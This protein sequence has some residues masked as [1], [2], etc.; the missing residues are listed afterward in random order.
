MTT[1]EI[2]VPD[3]GDF[4]EVEIIEILV[5]PGDTIAVDDPLITLESDKASME[6]PSSDAGVVKE[7]KVALGDKVSEGSLVLL[8][9]V[10]GES[11]ATGSDGAEA[12]PAEEA[13]TAP[14]APVEST[15]PAPAPAAPVTEPAADLR[16]VSFE[17]T[18]ASPSVR[19]IAREKGIDLNSLK[20]SGRKGRITR[21]DLANAG[22]RIPPA[23]VK[24]EVEA[25]RPATSAA[26]GGIPAIPEQDFSRFGEV[27]FQPLSKIKRLTGINLSRAWLNV[28]HVTHHDETDITEVEA[29]RKSLKAEAEKQGVRVTLLSFF[30][31]AC[32][33]T[34][35]AYPTFNASLDGSGENLILKKY[36]HIG[37]AVDTP[38]GLVVPVIRDVDRKSIFEISAELMEMSAKARDKKLKPGDMQGATFT[39][40]SLGG[41][42]GTAFTPIVNAPEVAILGLTRSQMKPVWDGSEFI[43]RLMQ[44][45]S[46]SYDHRVIDGA[47]AAHF[48]RHLGTLMNDVRRL[49]L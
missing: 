27:E 34:L 7:L 31:K 32:A 40:S 42:G 43:P 26:A 47:Q 22:Q 24:G 17:R 6:V 36:I 33:A 19:R 37:I 4:S 44:P 8:L 5:A 39:I 11:S 18:H 35:K 30:M 16:D 41:I 15:P 3:I 25:P 20:G 48:V 10:D 45:M 29:F 14:A 38:N 1:K 12:A 46:L 49:L 21:E 9:E 13:A 28:P 23:F 2:H